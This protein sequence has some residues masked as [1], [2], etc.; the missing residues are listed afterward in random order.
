MNADDF[1]R[2]E[3]DRLTEHAGFGFDTANAPAYDA[4]TVN[5]GRMGVGTHKSVG[6]KYAVLFEN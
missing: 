2:L 1:G 6:I 5:H 4:D 3:V